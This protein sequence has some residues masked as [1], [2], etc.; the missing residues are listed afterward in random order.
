MTWGHVPLSYADGSYDPLHGGQQ[1]GSDLGSLLISRMTWGHT[2]PDLCIL[3]IHTYDQQ[4]GGQR[5]ID[6]GI[7]IRPRG[8]EEHADF[9]CLQLRIK[10]PASLGTQSGPV[11]A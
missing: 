3:I 11:L 2:A 5:E 9:Y 6:P 10:H 7:N 1:R 4:H 8:S